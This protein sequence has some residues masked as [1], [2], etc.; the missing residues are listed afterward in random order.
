MT[1]ETATADALTGALGRF[2]PVPADLGRYDTDA[3]T[4]A[5]AL[6]A[7]SA[8]MVRLAENGLPHR[9][10][11]ERG[12]LFDYDDVMNVGMFC[13]TG[14]TVPEL[15]L[16]F[17]M[18][19]AASAR[20]TWFEPRTWQVGV[21]PSRTAGG[22]SAGPDASLPEVTVRVPDGTAPGLELLDPASFDGE[23][24]AR[25]LRGRGPADRRRPHRPRPADQTGVGRSGRRPRLGPGHLPDG[26]RVAA[27]ATTSVPGNSA[28]PTASSPPGCSPTG[29]ARPASRP[30]PAAA[31]CSACSAATTPGARSSRT[32][33]TRRWTRSSPSSRR[34]VTPAAPPSPRSSPP[35]AS[36]AASTGC[37]RAVPTAQSHSSISTAPPPPTGRWSASAPARGGTREHRAHPDPR[38]PRP[39]RPARPGRRRRRPGERRQLRRTHPGGTALRGVPRP[40]AGRRG[41]RGP[42]LG[43]GRRR[44]VA[45]TGEGAH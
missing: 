32:A 31:T 40:P 28:S 44:P 30:V 4:A 7:D 20:P 29:C 11:T 5:R 38:K 8:Q 13:G 19:F 17:L 22:A 39:P 21:H 6:R 45:G 41:T 34:S 12:P 23:P 27:R 18:R 25:R 10:D 43:A 24:A 3:D 1:V 26:A 36:A 37:C 16:R 9:M 42:H 35:P 14:Q 2:T 33:S 15:G